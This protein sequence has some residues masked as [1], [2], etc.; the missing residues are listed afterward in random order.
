MIRNIEYST[1][2]GLLTDRSGAAAPY[3][4]LTVRY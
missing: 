3:L 2:K 4:S 1:R